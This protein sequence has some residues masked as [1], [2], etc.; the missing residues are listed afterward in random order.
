MGEENLSRIVT[1]LARQSTDR[2]AEPVL[3]DLIEELGVSCEEIVLR[4][5][6]SNR[7][8]V[9]G[10]FPRPIVPVKTG[11][12]YVLNVNRDGIF[13]LLPEGIF[14][15]SASIDWKRF[16]V[17]KKR[18]TGDDARL[19]RDF[20][21]IFD[22][23]FN[24]FR[25]FIELERR[26]LF[27]SDRLWALEDWIPED[28]RKRLDYVLPFLSATLEADAGMAGGDLGLG[29]NTMMPLVADVMSFVLQERVKI[30][31]GGTIGRL[32]P[33]LPEVRLG[34]ITLGYDSVLQATRGPSVPTLFVNVGPGLSHPLK[35]YLLVNDP[36]YEGIQHRIIRYVCDVFLPAEFE[37]KIVPV[38][39]PAPQR[40]SL[41]PKDDTESDVGRLGY[42][43]Y[44]N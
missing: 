5:I 3:M 34:E 39:T 33:D 27:A 11:V 19:G 2:A 37:V 9:D 20:C 26:R 36:R 40:F 25:L 6:G 29:Q 21:L 15:I 24:L 1:E 10:P 43:T 12:G 35:D 16:Q 30:T 42:S 28:V 8:L 4:P 23:E 32:P 14:I 41:P 18:K 13:D 22:A 44:L 38:T 7:A 31:F 17:W